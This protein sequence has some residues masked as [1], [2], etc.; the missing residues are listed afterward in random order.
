M[1]KKIYSLV[2][3]V[4]FIILVIIIPYSTNN[5]LFNKHFDVNKN[6]ND[7]KEIN[8]RYLSEE[9]WDGYHKIKIPNDNTREYQY[10]NMN[11]PPPPQ[12]KK[13]NKQESPILQRTNVTN[14]MPSYYE[15]GEIISHN[16]QLLP[17]NATLSLLNSVIN[18]TLPNIP[19]NNSFELALRTIADYVTHKVFSPSILSHIIP[20]GG[21]VVSCYIMAALVGVFKYILFIYCS[22]KL[23]KAWYRKQCDRNKKD[24]N[25][26]NPPPPL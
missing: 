10:N 16:E 21:I 7:K 13:N 20:L 26:N 6:F 11:Y 23:F 12:K 4:S 3:I 19:E 15:N 9:M 2:N 14:Y 18:D 24:P 5:G 1:N 22:V 8:R 17:H 25:R